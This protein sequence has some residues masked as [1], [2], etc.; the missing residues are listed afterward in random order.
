MQD[1][2]PKDRV[3]LPTRPLNKTILYFTLSLC[4]LVS[5]L[6]YVNLPTLSAPETATEHAYLVLPTEK[7]PVAQAESKSPVPASPKPL[8]TLQK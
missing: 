6:I 2:K 8:P 4:L 1:Y 3:S 7:I 5:G